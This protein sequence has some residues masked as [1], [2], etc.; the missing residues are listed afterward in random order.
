MQKRDLRIPALVLFGIYAIYSCV[1]IPLYQF[2]ASDITLYLTL[3][4]D[5]VDFFLNLFEVLGIAA[6]FGFLI[7]GVYR[8]SVKNCRPLF[9][10][11]GGAL[12]FKYLA[13]FIA[14]SIAGGSI[15]LTYDFASYLVSFLMEAAELAFA[16]LLAHLLTST[17]AAEEKKRKKAA[18]LLGKE[19]SAQE[20]IPF[21]RPLSRTNA[22]QRTAFW[23]VL[24]MTA[25]RLIAYIISDISFS[26]VGYGYSASDIPVT[27][28]Y[29]LLLFL[30]PSCLGYLLS[31]GCM[32]LQA[33]QD[34]LESPTKEGETEK[35]RI[36]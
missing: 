8:H 18:R 14:I 3:W 23:S 27:L 12:L 20:L 2:I 16:V 35:D 28:I 31:L 7:Y 9:F 32:L 6:A 11:T 30:I 22:L 1:L 34:T 17:L 19:I 5:V 25:F 29:L 21:R 33:R 10:L 26:L 24:L 13:S 4:W 15:D 36:A